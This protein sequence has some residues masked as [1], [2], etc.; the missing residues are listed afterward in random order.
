MDLASCG[1]VWS[2]PAKSLVESDQAATRAAAPSLREGGAR[3]A[4]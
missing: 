2:D 1:F 4:R 3:V